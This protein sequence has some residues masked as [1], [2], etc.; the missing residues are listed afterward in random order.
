VERPRDA[1]SVRAVTT[2]RNALKS[3]DRKWLLVLSCSMTDNGTTGNQSTPIEKC[4][5]VHSVK[6]AVS[7]RFLALS[8]LCKRIFVKPWQRRR[9]RL[10][11]HLCSVEICQVNGFAFRVRQARTEP[12]VEPLKSARS[13]WSVIAN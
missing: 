12:L 4:R 2:Q 3:N 9:S 1:N 5:N 6:L 8:G 11:A 13:V 10:R 7:L